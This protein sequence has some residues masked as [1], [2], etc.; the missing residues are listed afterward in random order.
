MSGIGVILGAG[1]YAL[2]GPAAARAGGALWLAFVVAGAAAALTAYAY[3]RLGRM[4]PMDSPE[5]QYTALAFPAPVAFT[6]GWLML[7]ANLL[8]AAAVALG[9][10]G[11]LTHLAGTPIALNALALI[12]AVWIVSYVGIGQS[13][14]LA[15]VLTVVEALGLVFVIAIGVPSWPSGDFLEMPHGATGVLGAASL[16]FFAYLGFG[17]LGNFAEEMREPRRDLPRALAIAM[18]ATTAIYVLVAIS[19]VATIGWR[20]LSASPAPLATV[21]SHVLGERA[22]TLLGLVA[23]AATANTVLLLMVCAAR[24]AYGM[25][26]AGMLPSSLVRVGRTGTP[27]VATASI[28]AVA[29]VLVTVGDLTAVAALTDAAVL[30]SF[31]LVNASL[32]WL[33]LRD[34]LGGTRTQRAL[35]IAASGAAIVLCI[36]LLLHAGLASLCVAGAIVALG[37]I[38]SRFRVRASAPAVA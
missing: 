18:V 5:F 23:L 33:A 2:V 22:G 6:A 7:A 20:D 35:D 24:S 31:G 32:A 25:A 37:L 10:A 9:F 17:E 8:A 13:V 1:V 11:Y 29:A 14:G 36:V 3:A 4:R 21:A 19:A 27:T 26:G 28:V 30:A 15:V 38:V 12:G 34:R 16:I